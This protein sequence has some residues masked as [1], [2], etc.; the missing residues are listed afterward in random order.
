MNEP[1]APIPLEPSPAD[2]RVSNRSARLNVVEL[3]AQ[4]GIGPMSPL[5][6]RVWHGEARPCASC[7]HLVR[8]TDRVCGECGQDLSDDMI[9]KMRNHAGPWY[10]HEHVRP[11]P[12]VSL[13]RLIRQVRRGVLTRTTVVRGPTTDHQWRFA[14]ETPALSKHLGCCWVCQAAVQPTDA[15]CSTCGVDLDGGLLVDETGA[16]GSGGQRSA[17]IQQ[18]TSALSSLPGSQ[19]VHDEQIPARLGRFPVS[20]VVGGLAL[21]TLILVVVAVQLR[22]GARTSKPTVPR[23]VTVAPSAVAP[24]GEAP[25]NEAATSQAREGPKP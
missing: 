22:A 11:F 1:E 5:G 17:E 25:S 19:R 9:N 21:L 16:G 6:R 2:R 24:A 8:R 7:G 15:V 10:V 12:G 20:W 3:A 13:D 14:A 4:Q 18:L 23:D